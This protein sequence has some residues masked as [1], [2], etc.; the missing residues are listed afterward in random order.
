LPLTAF[1]VAPSRSM[2]TPLRDVMVGMV[3]S[4]QGGRIGLSEV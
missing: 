3:A 2:S 4:L 1:T